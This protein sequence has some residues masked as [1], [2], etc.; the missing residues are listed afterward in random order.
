[1]TKNWHFAIS[2]SLRLLTSAL[3]AC[4][5]WRFGQIHKTYIRHCRYQ[6]V[7]TALK[8]FCAL[9]VGPSPPPHPAAADPVIVHSCA[10]SGRHAVGVTQGVAFEIGSFKRS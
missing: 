2:S 3:S 7:F 4:T 8:V 5:F 1:M 10:F 6:S 9:H